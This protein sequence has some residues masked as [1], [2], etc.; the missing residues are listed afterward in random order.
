MYNEGKK[1]LEEIMEV[2][3]AHHKFAPRFRSVFF[4]L[5]G[6]RHPGVLMPRPTIYHCCTLP[7]VRALLYAGWPMY[8]GRFN[9]FVTVLPMRMLTLPLSASPANARSKPNSNDGNSRPSKTRLTRML[10]LSRVS[11]SYGRRT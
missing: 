11:R 10:R 1:G 6:R 3:K 2:M 4:F 5:S 8:H 9:N 7:S